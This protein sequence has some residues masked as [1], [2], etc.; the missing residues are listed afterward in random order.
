MLAKDSVEVE[1][2][3]NITPVRYDVTLA[4]IGE[5]KERY[6][7]LKIIPGDKESYEANRV[8]LGVVRPLRTAVDPK[9]K[10]MNAKAQAYIKK[11]ND[12]GKEIIRLLREVEDPLKADKDKEDDRLQAIEDEKI[13]AKQAQVD[14]VEA[15]RELA[16]N[17]S[18]LVVS[19]EIEKIIQAL[20]DKNIAATEFGEYWDDANRA[21]FQT[22]DALEALKFT[23]LE[24]EKA[25]AERKVEDER[26]TKEREEIEAK[27]KEMQGRQDAIDAENERKLEE[28]RKTQVE[29]QVKIDAE[30]KALADEA[31]K[32]V[33]MRVEIE[34]EKQA[35][36]DR[37]AREKREAI[38]REET[39]VQAEKDA[40]NLQIEVEHAR[41]AKIETDKAEIARQEG[42]KP[43]K[44]KLENF[45]NDLSQIQGPSLESKEAKG[46]LVRALIGIGVIESK[47]ISDI[48]NL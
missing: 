4:V 45:S 38:I 40:A 12:E 31:Q 47:I 43:D 19:S 22:M 20:D 28:T 30:K 42:L 27:A 15:I 26:L 23:R 9:R 33:D 46:V 8:A 32:L 7:D 21:K 10:E 13:R 41:L 3:L 48:E 2:E 29:A 6:K 11:V 36:V 25:D 5:L 37:I 24:V 18:P 1:P 16:R 44:E 34:A 14:A 39:K 35:E 17:I